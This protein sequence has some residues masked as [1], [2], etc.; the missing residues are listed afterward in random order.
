[1]RRTDP[2]LEAAAQEA[3]VFMECWPGPGRVHPHVVAHRNPSTKRMT[4]V[5]RFLPEQMRHILPLV[6]A[7]EGGTPEEQTRS[8]MRSWDGP[9]AGDLPHA[10]HDPDPELPTFVVRFTPEQF[11]Y[12]RAMAGAYR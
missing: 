8:L 12:L 1:M 7:D 9:P 3:T 10:I 6:G 4:F 11:I 5:V 2:E